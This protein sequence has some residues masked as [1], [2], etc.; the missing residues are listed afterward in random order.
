M[1]LWEIDWSALLSSFQVDSLGHSE[2]SGTAGGGNANLTPLTKEI[3]V[4]GCSQAVNMNHEVFSFLY[5][6]NQENAL[7]Q[8]SRLRK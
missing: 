4:P 1:S 2:D 8:R 7:S 5:A 3:M 6:C